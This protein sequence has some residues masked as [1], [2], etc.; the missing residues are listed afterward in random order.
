MKANQTKFLQYSMWNTLGEIPERQL[1]WLIGSWAF[2]FRMFIYPLIDPDLFN[3]L[4]SA[5]DSRPAVPPQVIVSLLII[6]RMFNMTDMDVYNRMLGG[7]LAFRVATNTF[8]IPIN[9]LPVN[10]NALSRM[11][12]RCEE[13]A[14]THDGYNPL[15]ECM[16]ELNWA[17]CAISGTP[18]DTL[19]VDSLQVSAN[20]AY[21]TREALI[22]LMNQKMLG[23]LKA[24]HGDK[25]DQR[26]EEADLKHYFELYDGNKVLY[27]AHDGANKR[28]K[29]A[30][31]A[32]AVLALCEKEELE[33]ELG[34]LFTRVL[35]EQ[36]VVE[37][38]KRRFAKKED[39][40]MGSTILQNPSDPNATNRMKAFKRFIGYTLNIVEAVGKHGSLVI[41]WDFEQNVVTDPVMAMAFINHASVI[42]EGVGKYN[43]LLGIENPQDMEKCLEVL[44]ARKEEVVSMLMDARAAGRRIPRTSDFGI[45]TYDRVEDNGSVVTDSQQIDMDELLAGLG[46]FK[47]DIPH[48][49]DATTAKD[50]SAA[51]KKD[52]KAEETP[53]NPSTVVEYAEECIVDS[54]E[55]AQQNADTPAE[56]A[57]SDSPNTAEEAQQGE[58]K[59]EESKASVWPRLMFVGTNAYIDGIPVE[60]Y[61][62]KPEFA[63]LS[64]NIRNEVIQ[65]LIRKRMK[66][67]GILDRICNANTILA[68]DGAYS[69]PDL[70]KAAATHGIVL[71]PTD[72]LGV[73][74][75]P[76]LGLFQFD[77]VNDQNHVKACPMGHCP[78]AQKT[79]ANGSVRVQMGCG[80]CKD[81]P[82]RNDCGAAWQGKK[83]TYAF[84]VAPNAQGR[85]LTMAL[86]RSDEYKDVG[87]FRNGVE[88]IPS[89]LRLVMGIDDFPIGMDSKK[90]YI[91]ISITSFN[92]WKLFLAFT[93]KSRIKQNSLLA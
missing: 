91:G 33:S 12:I 78:E 24:N 10:H 18:L 7:D 84:T 69:T 20:I 83:Q 79:Y 77:T 11:R 8:S 67:D 49:A 80:C 1:N 37:D 61:A 68:A 13:Y 16:A 28:E 57:T 43:K 40:T 17:M 32:S 60:E 63:E 4:Y 25:L 51:Q 54:N 6:Q 36:T 71:L 56:N 72:L 58:A 76:I 2:F 15:L 31:E 52:G 90:T 74:P 9:D 5:A 23:L 65:V 38:G 48:E 39:G 30:Q 62:R 27:Y 45:Y 55:T 29:L 81:C 19:R 46:V 85:A 14:K 82:F 26:M 87:R 88:T 75:K 92:A 35:S 42:V 44:R 47:L 73:K 64:E 22:Y 3:C 89:F 86:I 53:H 93:G 59:A 21:L 50:T 41:S 70:L 34:V 66:L